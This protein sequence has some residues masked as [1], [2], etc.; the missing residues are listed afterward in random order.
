LLGHRHV[1][2]YVA[3]ARNLI[4]L[5]DNTFDVILDKGTLDAIY[6]SGGSKV[7]TKLTSHLGSTYLAQAI[8]ELARVMAPGGVLISLS[9][10][11]V[12][13]VQYTLHQ[14]LTMSPTGEWTCL[15]D[16]SFFMTE[17]GYTSNNVDGNLFAYQRKNC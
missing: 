17:D 11:C 15:R 4:Q 10:A 13:A 5:K 12:D 16:G 7:T 1:P 6:L 9:A 3:D 14:E 2:I 8:R